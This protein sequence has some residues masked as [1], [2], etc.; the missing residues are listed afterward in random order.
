MKQPMAWADIQ[1]KARRQSIYDK[2]GSLIA[3]K[4]YHKL[5]ICNVHL[6]IAEMV[7]KSETLSLQEKEQLMPLID[8]A[9]N[10]GKRMDAKLVYLK[11]GHEVDYA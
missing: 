7:A 6:R 4:S 5:S 11:A 3:P 9:Y 10:L 1:A 8:K 2:H